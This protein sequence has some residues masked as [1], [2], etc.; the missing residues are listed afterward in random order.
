MSVRTL[1]SAEKATELKEKLK[2]KILHILDKLK[3]AKA[4]H[5]IDVIKGICLSD[6][7]VGRS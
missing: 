7:S 1:S 6:L 3:L 5:G 4:C 2:D